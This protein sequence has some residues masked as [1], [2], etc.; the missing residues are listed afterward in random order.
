MNHNNTIETILIQYNDASTNRYYE[1][2]DEIIC[3]IRK[4]GTK[5]LNET[6]LTIMNEVIEPIS[7]DLIRM[8]EEIAGKPN[9]PHVKDIERL[10]THF[11]GQ[12][13][14]QLSLEA[15]RAN[16]FSK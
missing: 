7:F 13:F 3:T 1:N 4:A 5:Y 15:Y 12:T 8:Y 10:A 16:K 9:A 14:M 6:M 11:V 2:M